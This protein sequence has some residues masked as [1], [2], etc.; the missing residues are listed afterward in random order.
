MIRDLRLV[1]LVAALG[2]TV[3]VV[4]ASYLLAVRQIVL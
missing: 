1:L 2:I 3:G 4:L